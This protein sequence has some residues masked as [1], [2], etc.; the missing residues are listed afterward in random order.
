M[1]SSNQ[2]QV[3]AK[4]DQRLRTIRTLWFA[5]FASL[6]MYY[7]LTIFTKVEERPSP[8]LSLALATAA[9]LLVLASFLIKQR[10][11]SQS[12]EKQ[13][14]A[15]VQVGYVVGLAVCEVAALLG[16]LDHFLTGNRYYYLL[17]IA[18]AMGD[19]LHFPQRRHLQNAAFKGLF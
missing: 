9:A 5:I 17:I 2:N 4:V 16:V 11:L 6:A 15:L 8:H 13:D 19:L 3:E 10:Y 18:A 7:V 12:V 1:Q 14:M